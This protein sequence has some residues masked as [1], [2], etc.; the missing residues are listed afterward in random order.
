[1]SFKVQPWDGAVTSARL[2]AQHAGPM[3]LL[4]PEGDA[5]ERVPFPQELSVVA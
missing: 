3:P 2:E 4:P 5:D 1:M